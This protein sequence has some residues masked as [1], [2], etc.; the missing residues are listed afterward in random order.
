MRPAPCRCWAL[1]FKKKAMHTLLRTILIYIVAFIVALALPKDAV[2][3][4]IMSIAAVAA[5][6][7]DFILFLAS[8][9]GLLHHLTADKK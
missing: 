5:A 9:R 2:L 3:I 7:A 6:T 1:L 8:G 4:P